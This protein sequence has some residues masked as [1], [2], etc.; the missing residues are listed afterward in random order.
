MTQEENRCDMKEIYLDN[1]ATTK[2]YD[3]VAKLVAKVM[4]E[5]YG[6]PSSRHT[7]GIDAERFVTDAYT[8]IASI[9]KIPNDDARRTLY[10]TSGGTE[11]DNWAI[12]E[13]C[14]AYG[15]SGKHIITTHIE[16]P[17]ILRAMERC[18]KNGFEITYLSTDETGHIKLDE[19]KDNIREDTILVSIMH[20]NNEIGAVQD[21]EKIGRIIKET[22]PETLFHSDAVQGFGKLPVIPKKWNADMISMSSHKFHGPKGVGIF[23]CNKNVKLRPFIVGGGQQSGQRSGTLNVPGIAGT[24]LAAKMCY[25]DRDA[26]NERLYDLREYFINEVLHSVPDTVLNGSL[27]R[28]LSAPHI[29][30][31]SFTGVRSEVLLHSLEEK[32]IYVSSGSA[33]SSHKNKLEMSDTFKSIGATNE[34]AESAI[35]FSMCDETSKEDLD[36]TLEALNELVPM[37]R[38][39]VRH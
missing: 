33:C 12:E 8:D 30:N 11:S 26:K 2:A 22:N 20:V 4:C 38:R 16:H 3:D 17:A 39:F 1:S 21:M 5:E 15:R 7:K 18:E 27:D 10:F 14:E 9:M 36:I 13:T 25:E 19:L 31:I 6:N 37:L 32:G 28:S 34:R 29:I 35:R 24:A 23:Y